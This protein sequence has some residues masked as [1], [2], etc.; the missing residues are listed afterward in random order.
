MWTVLPM[1]SKEFFKELRGMKT[2]S[3]EE[4]LM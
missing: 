3:D 4:K 2:F 1:T